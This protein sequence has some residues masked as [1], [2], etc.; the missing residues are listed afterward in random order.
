[1]SRHRF[2]SQPT[3]QR[4]GERGSWAMVG[5]IAL[6]LIGIGAGALLGELARG[7]APPPAQ[8]YSATPMDEPATVA[9]APA[10]PQ[11]QPTPAAPQATVPDEKS[12]SRGASP[13]VLA[14]KATKPIR[15]TH[16][17]PPQLL[18]AAA[19]IG[20]GSWEQQQQD[21]ERA[22]TAYDANERT[23]GYQWA[24]QNRIRIA[25]HCRVAA[26]RTPAFVDGCLNY[27]GAR[28]T[29]GSPKPREPANDASPGVG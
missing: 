16:R 17:S 28:R 29:G 20:P 18:A 26:Q 9:A 19:P 15:P 4:S 7:P 24:Q 3:L 12:G 13:R 6:A 14:A 22:R 11:V 27:L 21:Y 10:S 5:V 1:M 23:A 25:R 8:G 2:R